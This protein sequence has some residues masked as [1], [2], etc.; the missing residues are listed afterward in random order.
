MA[1][2]PGE[3]KKGILR[4]I[5]LVTGSLEE[6]KRWRQYKAR[7]QRLPENYR[8]A[9]EATERYLIHLALTDGSVEIWE[10]LADLFEQSVADGT[11]VRSLFGDDPAEFAETF[12][13]NYPAGQWRNQERNRF[14][15]AVQDA[16]RH[17][18]SA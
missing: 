4:Y 6:K 9:A 13:A 8:I 5:E 17:D 15:R 16:S 18:T 2:Q 14:A 10:D 3:Q 1:T 7:V 12:A 11:A